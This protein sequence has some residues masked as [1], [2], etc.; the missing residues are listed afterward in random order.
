MRLAYNGAVKPLGGVPRTR[1]W[2]LVLAALLLLTAAGCAS[3]GRRA[4]NATSVP[5]A[6][7]TA[8]R[9]AATAN[10]TRERPP[11]EVPFPTP[12]PLPS[13]T[14]LGP[15]DA[16]QLA[17]VVARIGKA[18]ESPELTGLRPLM[19]EQI[20]IAPGGEQGAETMERDLAMNWLRERVEPKPRVISSNRVEAYGLLE[21][22]SGPWASKP[23]IKSEQIQFNLHQY[24]A[25]GNQVVLNGDWMID[26]IIPR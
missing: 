10:P 16:Q 14:R 3:S 20:A 13:P 17:Q 18:L 11:T 12:R 23:P 24:D 8:A 15:S 1:R 22:V 21:V 5:G 4:S 2:L 19:L 26:T 7:A 6:A 25:E 9:L